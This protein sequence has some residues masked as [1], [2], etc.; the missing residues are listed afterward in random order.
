MPTAIYNKEN[1]SNVLRENKNF[2]SG[3]AKVVC[4]LNVRKEKS[5]LEAIAEIKREANCLKW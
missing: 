3:H 4:M 2:N 1:K 5:R